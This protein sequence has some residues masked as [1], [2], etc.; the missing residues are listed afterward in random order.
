MQCEA[1]GR[2]M[3]TG[4]DLATFAER[5]KDAMERWGEAV[6]VLRILDVSA[7]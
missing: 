1:D 3:L 6:M 2:V 4:V 5:V 7:N